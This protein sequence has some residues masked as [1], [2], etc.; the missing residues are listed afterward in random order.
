MTTIREK[1]IKI[2]CP[3][4]GSKHI[5]EYLYGLPI[6]SASLEKKVNEG[7]IILGGCIITEDSPKYWCHDCE[8]NF[9]IYK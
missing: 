3:Y 5:G 9:G 2:T 7:K 6:F 4:C 1:P 8:K